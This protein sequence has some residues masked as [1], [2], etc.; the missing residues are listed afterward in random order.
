[1]S[2]TRKQLGNGNFPSRLP[3]AEPIVKE[4]SPR[5]YKVDDLTW[6]YLPPV[7]DAGVATPISKLPVGVR[8]DK[9]GNPVGGR[10]TRRRKSTKKRK[11]KK[12]YKSRKGKK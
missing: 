2:R 1:M 11:N 3:N 8:L 9:H 5:A 7:G 12:G 6:R 10:R 4:K